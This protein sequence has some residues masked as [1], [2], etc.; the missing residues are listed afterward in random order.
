MRA[1]LENRGHQEEKLDLEKFDFP[2]WDGRESHINLAQVINDKIDAGEYVSDIRSYVWQL[3]YAY[4]KTLEDWI[5][6]D[7]DDLR[8]KKEELEDELDELKNDLDYNSDKDLEDLKKTISEVEEEISEIEEKIE[9]PRRTDWLGIE[10]RIDSD[11]EYRSVQLMTTAG[12]PNCYI[13][14]ADKKFHLYSWGEHYS[15]PLS[16]EV[17]DGLDEEMK[18][19]YDCTIGGM[20][21]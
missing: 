17:C 5:G 2:I 3:K 12:G 20:I 14:T 6:Q 15:V 9:D 18:E 10:Y 21:S 11:G 4:E 1:S 7:P 13:D 16:L 19:L 8:D